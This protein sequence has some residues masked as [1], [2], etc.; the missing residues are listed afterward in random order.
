M[1]KIFDKVDVICEIKSDG[2]VIPIRFRLLNEDGEFETYK[3]SSYRP[4]P[5]QGTYTTKD[6][7]YVS[8]STEIFECRVTI[9]GLVRTVRLYYDPKNT[10]IWKL[11]V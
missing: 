10:S 5:K 3:I 1:N 9:F 4:V 11:A 2:T 7:I 8:N 6:K